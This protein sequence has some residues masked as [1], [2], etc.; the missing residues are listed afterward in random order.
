MERGG[1]VEGPLL[2]E[3]SRGPKR[4][5]S[6]TRRNG[7]QK[8]CDFNR[9]P[10]RSRGRTGDTRTNSLPTTASPGY[11]HLLRVEKRREW[12]GDPGHQY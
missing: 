6:S 5:T 1:G 11:T 10:F 12:N 7:L 3:G 8:K 9:S 4:F 2:A